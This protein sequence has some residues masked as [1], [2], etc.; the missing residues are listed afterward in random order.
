VLRA[1]RF[2]IPAVL[3]ALAFAAPAY[4]EDPKSQA[5]DRVA[6][7]FIAPETG[8]AAHPRFFTERELGFFT[9]I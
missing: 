8:G 2:S 4:A 6:V 1:R 5:A 7:R 3:A 9:R